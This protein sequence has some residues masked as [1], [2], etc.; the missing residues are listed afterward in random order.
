[1]FG[2]NYFG[3]AFYGPRYWAPALVTPPS[4]VIPTES[5]ASVYGGYVGNR[6]T[7]KER[8][9]KLGIVTKSAKLVIKAIAKKA[10][11]LDRSPG[12]AQVMLEFEFARKKLAFRPDYVKVLAYER[13]IVRQEHLKNANKAITASKSRDEDDEDD[14]EILML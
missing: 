3:A 11:L 1:M 7:P 2:H 10:E 4:A 5:T 14:L 8:R 9:A 6:S 12:E 13:L